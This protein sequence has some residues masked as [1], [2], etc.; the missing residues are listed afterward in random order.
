MCVQAAQKQNVARVAPPPVPPNKE[1]TLHRQKVYRLQGV[2]LP[3]LAEITQCNTD[4]KIKKATPG[5]VWLHTLMR[6]YSS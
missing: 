6:S 1:I 2:P 3:I 4:P 5:M